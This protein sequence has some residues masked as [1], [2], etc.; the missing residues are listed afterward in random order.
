MRSKQ[1]DELHRIDHVVQYTTRQ[2]NVKLWTIAATE[3][4]DK[5]AAQKSDATQAEDLLGDQAF[6]ISA[7]VVVRR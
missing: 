2:A 4:L 1:P 6:E 5:I 3:I 7:R